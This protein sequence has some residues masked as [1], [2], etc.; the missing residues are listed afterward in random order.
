M[1]RLRLAFLMQAWL[2]WFELE[3]GILRHAFEDAPL[4]RPKFLYARLL[5]NAF[6]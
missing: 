2:C 6:R 3:M 4:L 1:R 5:I